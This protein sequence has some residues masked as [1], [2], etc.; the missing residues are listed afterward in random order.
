MGTTV[1][2]FFYIKTPDL[3]KTKKLFFWEGGGGGGA[4]VSELSFLQTIQI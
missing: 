2:D 1:S 4:R 3:R